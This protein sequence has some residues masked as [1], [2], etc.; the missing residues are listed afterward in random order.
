[1][2]RWEVEVVIFLPV[3]IPDRRFFIE[4]RYTYDRVLF[5]SRFGTK[6]VMRGILRSAVKT[7]YKTCS[8][9]EFLPK[10]FACALGIWVSWV[11]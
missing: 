2:R 11:L 7:K 8:S 10:I 1:M 5:L 3:A 6:I 9:Q 4:I